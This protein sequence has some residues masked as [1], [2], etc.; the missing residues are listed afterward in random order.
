MPLSTR[1]SANF[2]RPADTTAY[3]SGDLVANSTVAGS[4]APMQFATKRPGASQRIAAATIHKSNNSV[5][6]ASFRL[7][8]F[9][10]TVAV[11]NGDNGV[12]TPAALTGYLGA[13]DVTV[14]LA[15]TVGA[16]GVG[17]PRTGAGTDILAPAAGP[18]FGLLEARSAYTPASGEV[19]TVTL[20][21]APE[22]V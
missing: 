16:V 8:L 20:D 18:I 17:V 21:L 12:F 15:G 14:D 9:N 22:T 10:A 1:P 13:I 6:T 4:V 7:H 3:T 5:V 19:F 2:T 11:A